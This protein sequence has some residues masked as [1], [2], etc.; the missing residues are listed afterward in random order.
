MQFVQRDSTENEDDL[1]KQIDAFLKL[2][3]EER[4]DLNSDIEDNDDNAS[5]IENMV[6]VSSVGVFHSIPKTPFYCPHRCTHLSC[7]RPQAA[8]WYANCILI[9]AV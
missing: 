1:R 8:R 9:I 5:E 7:C 2:S 4:E 3:E 6:S